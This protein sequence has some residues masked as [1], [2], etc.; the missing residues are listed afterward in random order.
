MPILPVV[1][2]NP[3][4]ARAASNTSAGVKASL[5]VA[6]RIDSK[7]NRMQLEVYAKNKARCSAPSAL[8]KQLRFR[9]TSA[10]PDQPQPKPGFSP[11]SL[12]ELLVVHATTG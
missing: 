1:V 7:P 11:W 6:P 10:Q 8:A 4:R 12:Y 5:F 2:A 3:I 9:T